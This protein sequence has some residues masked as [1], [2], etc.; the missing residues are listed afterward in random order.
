MPLLSPNRRTGSTLV[1]SIVLALS[2]LFVGGVAASITERTGDG[3]VGKVTKT[4]VTNAGGVY[5]A[6]GGVNHF[7]P[8]GTTTGKFTVD[9]KD[10]S[11]EELNYFGSTFCLVPKKGKTEPEAVTKSFNGTA[12]VAGKDKAK[13]KVR[14]P[15]NH[16]GCDLSLISTVLRPGDGVEQSEI[17]VRKMTLSATAS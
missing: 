15:K 4:T 6:Q 2:L 8:E 5:N 10:K 1:I 16:L 17:I 13:V 9:V 3:T 12:S 14:L 7:A 11:V